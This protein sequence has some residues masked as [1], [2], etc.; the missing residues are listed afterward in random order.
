MSMREGATGGCLCGAV[1][2]MIG[3]MPR[4]VVICHCVFCRRTAT[5][6]GAYIRCAP[7]DLTVSGSKKLRWYRSSPSARRGF[8]SKCGSQ[9]FWEPADEAHIAV[10]AGSVDSAEGFR[11][12]EQ[13]FQEQRAAYEP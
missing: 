8:C 5:H 6:V 7:A 12:T 10:S 3:R 1:R 13:L 2:Y 4:D 11:V 9:L